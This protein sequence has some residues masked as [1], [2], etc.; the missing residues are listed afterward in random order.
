MK[1]FDHNVLGFIS[2]FVFIGCDEGGNSSEH[3]IVGTHQLTELTVMKYAISNVD[4]FGISTIDL[5]TFLD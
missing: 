2:L 4:T 1:V 3:P 5:D